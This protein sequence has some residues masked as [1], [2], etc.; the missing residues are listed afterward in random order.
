MRGMRSGLM[1]MTVLVGLTAGAAQA[2]WV[3]ATVY[4]FE[5]QGAQTLANKGT[6]GGSLSPLGTPE[7]VSSPQGQAYRL[8][9]TKTGQDPNFTY[10]SEGLVADAF[11]NPDYKNGF[12]VEVSFRAPQAQINDHARLVDHGDWYLSMLPSGQIR[13]GGTFG[14]GTDTARNVG[15]DLHDGQWHT[16]VMVYDPTVGGEYGRVT[17]TVDG[18]ASI[19]FDLPHTSAPDFSAPKT[20]RI[21]TLHSTTTSNRAFRGDIDYV[22][23]LVVPEPGAVG[24]LGLAGGSLLLSRRGR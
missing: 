21:G 20:L 18:S 6:V 1:A 7:L 9:A 19:S 14:G 2:A 22:K 16:V 5:G 11:A 8:E 15:T 4:D 24:L 10:T 13:F 3:D 23:I 17:A 12:R